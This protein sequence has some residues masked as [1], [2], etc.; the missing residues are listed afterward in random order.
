MSIITPSDTALAYL[1]QLTIGQQRFDI[2]EQS[3]TTGHTATRLG[4]PPR[5]TVALR[6]LDALEPAVSALWK[7]IA[8]QLRGRVNHL[9]LHDITQPQPRGL[10][11]GSLTLSSTAAAGAT[12]L[13]LAGA[14]GSNRVL[15]G[16]FEVDSNADGL[17][18][19]WTRYSAGTV[20]SLTHSLSSGIVWGGAYSQNL[21]A[22]SLGGTAGDRQGVQAALFN[23]PSLAGQ[24]VIISTRVLGTSGTKAS[25][26][27]YWRDVGGTI[28]GS[29]ISSALTL[30]GLEQVITATG[31]CPVGTVS[32]DV[33]AYQHSGVAGAVGVYFDLAR[34]EPGAAVGSGADATLLAGDWLQ[35]GS[36]VGS[37]FCMVTAD[38]TATDNGAMTVTVEP[39]LRK[40]FTSST[41]VTWDKPKAHYKQ[42][43]DSLSWSGA[44]GSAMVGG[45]A[46]DLME[47]WSA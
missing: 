36:G 7:A 31:S 8:V 5:W 37:H 16:S 9:A 13:A 2:S 3:D 21:V 17:A 47:D 40:S 1:E 45:F 4:G 41:A 18:D 12:S 25:L 20:G 23:V 32:G 6:T 22:A 30:N 10:A 34:V 39:P 29:V 19:R 38:A 11:R 33:Y 24:S 26:E 35:I 15:N 44:A 28:I 27:V 43:P 14:V 42:R 46:F